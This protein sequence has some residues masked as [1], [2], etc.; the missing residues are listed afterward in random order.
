M[1]PLAAAAFRPFA[2]ARFAHPMCD[3]LTL[4]RFNQKPWR[5]M[6]R[7][8]CRLHAGNSVVEFAGRWT[9]VALLAITTTA[10]SMAAVLFIT[11]R[12]LVPRTSISSRGAAV[13]SR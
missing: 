4:K 6:G 10:S 8:S 12:A 3:S 2:R 9:A 7:S 5:E 11:A 13:Y 1:P